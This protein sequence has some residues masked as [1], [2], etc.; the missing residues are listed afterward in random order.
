MP[1]DRCCKIKY[2]AELKN[3][4]NL[5]KIFAYE[6]RCGRQNVDKN[7]IIGGYYTKFKEFPWMAIIFYDKTKENGECAGSVISKNFVLTAAHCI[8]GRILSVY[9]KP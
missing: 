9:G 7:K 2:D 1:S 8:T 6:L 5:Q 4:S 3:V